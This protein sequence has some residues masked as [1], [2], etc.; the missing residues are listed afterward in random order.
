LKGY[1]IKGIFFVL[2]N[3]RT[4]QAG[5]ERPEENEIGLILHRLAHEEC[6][7]IVKKSKYVE[8]LCDVSSK[9]ANFYDI[10]S[11]FSSTDLKVKSAYLTLRP[12]QDNEEVITP[13]DAILKNVEPMQI[14]AFMINL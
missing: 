4:M 3:M 1:K 9:S 8:E 5:D 2:V 11:Y 10:F 7:P 6:S 12:K 14:E 13:D